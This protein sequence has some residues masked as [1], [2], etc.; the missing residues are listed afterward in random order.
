MGGHVGGGTD[1][2]LVM[3]GKYLG[4]TY[5]RHTYTL[6]SILGILCKVSAAPMLQERQSQKARV[7][8]L[9]YSESYFTL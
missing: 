1:V 6:Q 2:P 5:R 3:D 7:R 9:L 8:I 4:H